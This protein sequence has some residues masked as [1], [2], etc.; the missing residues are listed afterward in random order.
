MIEIEGIVFK[1]GIKVN[2]ATLQRNRLS[3]ETLIIIMLLQ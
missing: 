1:K 3:K 2:N